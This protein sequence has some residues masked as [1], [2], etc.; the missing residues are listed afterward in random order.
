MTATQGILQ[1]NI[2][3]ASAN[4]QELQ[5]ICSQYK[6]MVVALQETLQR[7]DKQLTLNNFIALT[8]PAQPTVEGGVTG[9]VGLFIHKTVLY[10]QIDLH[11]TLQAVAARVSLHKTIT[12]CSL[13]LPPKA[14]I[15]RPDLIALIQQLPR[16]FMILGDFNGH[17]PL[18]GSTKSSQRG[19]I[20]EKVLDE[21]NLCCLNNGS[22]T[23][24][25][26]ANGTKSC[27][28][29][30]ICDSSL[31]LDYNWKVDDD[32]HGSDHFPIHLRHTNTDT[33]DTHQYLNYNRANWDLFSSMVQRQLQ[34]EE[35]LQSDDPVESLTRVLLHCAK[36]TIPSS[37]RKPQMPKTPW[38]N[39]EC[40]DINKARKKSQRQVFKH[41]TLEN[42]KAHQQ[43]RA[44]S[45]LVYKTAKRQSWKTFCSSITSKT[46][47]KKVW[48]TIKKIK[49]KSTC[50]SVHH[51]KLSDTLI[52][53]KKAVSNLLASTIE[54]TASPSNRSP[55]FLKNE[56]SKGKKPPNFTSDNT[57]NYNLPFTLDELKTA[58]L[59]CSDSAPGPD[60][61][62]YKILKHLPP[63][64]LETLLQVF[65]HIWTSGTFPPSWRRAT[66]IPIPKPGKDHSNPLNY[67]PIAL[68]SCL[69]KLLEK[70]VNSRLMWKLE[71]DN[72]LAK[73]QCGFR[74]YHSTTDHLIRLESTIRNAFLRKHHVVAIFF[75]MEKA[76]D[77]TWK[78][79]IISDLHDLGFRGHL[80][81]FIENFLAD[82]QFQVRVGTTLSDIHNQEMGVPQG[83]ILSPALFNIKINNIVKSFQGPDCSLFVDDFAICASGGVYSGVQR[84]LQ[85][86][87]NKVRQWAEE[88]GFTFSPTKTQCI[89]F[90]NQRTYFE[91]PKIQLG[92]TEIPAVKEAKFLGVIFDQKLNFRSHI[93]H[94]KTSCQ[95][96]LNILRVV[97]HTDWGADKKT[98]LLLYRALIRSKLDY[99]CVVY[100][101]ARES[102]LKVLNSIHHQGLRLCLGALRTSPVQ[103]LY[104]EAGEPSLA[105]RR[106]RLSLSYY[107][108]IYSELENPAY[109]C[110]FD[111]RLSE[112]YKKAPGC[113]PPF[114]LRTRPHAQE[115]GIDLGVIC[116]FPKFS[117]D[118]HW[119]YITPEVRFDLASY[120]KENT[121]SLVY[122]GLYGSLCENYPKHEKIFTDGSKTA[123]GVGASAVHLA[124]VV[125]KSN[126]HLPTDSSVYTAELC[127]LNLALEMIRTSRGKKFIIFSDS[128]SALEA[129]SLRN[130]NHPE[131]LDFFETYT[132]LKKK[133][134][135]IILAWVPGHVGIKGNELADAEAKRA[136]EAAVPAPFN[137]LPFTDLKRKIHCYTNNLWQKEW[138][139]NVNNKLYEARPTLSESLPSL[140]GNRKENVVLTRLR[141]GH[142]YLTHSYLL[143]GEEAPWCTS[144]QEPQTVKHIL[145]TCKEFNE[146]RRKHYTTETIR[147]LFRDVPPWIILDFVKEIGL[148]KDI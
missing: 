146:I 57:E 75:D 7:E 125:Q 143:R 28:D 27:L 11:T 109:K 46:S 26:P 133:K 50:P 21:L 100:G 115:A 70:M 128:L 62:H 121:N 31:F 98:L 34:E 14:N 93:K 84:R 99:G 105:N 80:P 59:N 10:S 64:S 112:E 48:N 144:C 148:F 12:I 82:R 134:R 123:N 30:S 24:I 79:G 22:T 56:K 94:V 119:T 32:L 136:A 9:G 38:F 35:I 122:K 6:P 2:R 36:E 127:A 132:K 120:R 81:R 67:R 58:L 86:C 43:L 138:D 130:L 18:W 83:S 108:K 140:G 42:I 33:Q 3:G 117:E 137:I 1:W 66:V 16:P 4:Y 131:L 68:T 72:L 76:Y 47:K 129:I 29:L 69:C 13:Y 85:L 97:A 44:K 25:Y 145:I 88:N 126:K 61:I 8:E 95:K 63:S 96:A 107:V 65:N 19:Q 103:S 74:K 104:A 52:T 37:S 102:Y 49:G 106:L 114:G 53:D 51:L 147:T 54:K 55:A 60:E 71:T 73:Q 135:D 40:R 20:L 23:Y 111:D 113:I 78:K 90:H 87:V 141:I 15:Q 77:T 39:Q 5:L 17:S 116:D 118:P 110:I 142:T 91:D 101:S 139:E 89:H 92:E 41:P 124:D 45:R